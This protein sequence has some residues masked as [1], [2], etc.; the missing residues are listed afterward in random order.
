MTTFS[1]RQL[2]RETLLEE[3]QV[4]PE[5]L[6]KAERQYYDALSHVAELK[7][8]LTST[9]CEL[10]ASGTITGKNEAARLAE[11]W[12]QTGAFHTEIRQ[13]ENAADRLKSE[14]YFLRRKLDNAQLMA[15][16]LSEEAYT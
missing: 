13:A 5:L 2:V 6:R 12:P 14:V 1:T 9:E 4:V 15:K 11:M 8:K 10:Y 7:E 16:L 3:L